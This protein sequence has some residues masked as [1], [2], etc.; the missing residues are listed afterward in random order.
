MTD[1]TLLTPVVDNPWEADELLR[2]TV[3]ALNTIPSH[4]LYGKRFRTTYE[5]STAIS[6]YLEGK[7]R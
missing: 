6:K 7:P 5:L 4:K 3:R 2:E 1:D